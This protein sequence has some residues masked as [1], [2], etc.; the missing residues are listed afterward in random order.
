M[1]KTLYIIRGIPGAGKT[2]LG[3]KLTEY[4][5]AADDFMVNEQGEYEFVP[6]RLK[7]CHEKCFNKVRNLLHRGK[8]TVAVTNTFKAEW[9]Y[10]R[11]IFLALAYG[12]TVIALDVSSS[13]KSVHG[14]S[15]A[16]VLRFEASF[17]HN[18][19]NAIAMATTIME[20]RPYEEPIASDGWF[21]DRVNTLYK[22]E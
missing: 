12:Y 4:C 17:Q 7:E 18:I 8:E 21:V 6:T 11:Y 9:E 5:V 19:N 13:N 3:L 15:G 10:M 22:E 20:G 2:T 1:A 14:L 16:D